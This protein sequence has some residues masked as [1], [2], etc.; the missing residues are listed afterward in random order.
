MVLLIIMVKIDRLKDLWP[1]K[2]KEAPGTVGIRSCASGVAFPDK[3]KL[4]TKERN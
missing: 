2:A 3:V 4:R 1:S